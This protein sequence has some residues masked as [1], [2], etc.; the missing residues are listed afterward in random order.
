[1]RWRAVALLGLA[2]ALSSLSAAFAD[3]VLEQNLFFLNVLPSS[4][5]GDY[6]W[7]TGLSNNLLTA[8]DTFADVYLFNTPLTNA[9]FGFNAQASGVQFTSLLLESA[10]GLFGDPTQ[11]S[12]SFGS[13]SLDDSDISAYGASLDSGTYALVLT[14]VVLSDGGGYNGSLTTVPEPQVLALC[15][16][17]LAGLAAA[18]R[19]RA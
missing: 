17:A 9:L 2:L 18:R 19:R 15:L 11:P 14:G 1:M 7:G 6:S 5:P 16:I 10:A 12:Y 8:G 4:T 13:V 3:P